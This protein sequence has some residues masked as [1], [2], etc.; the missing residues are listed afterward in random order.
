LVQPDTTYLLHLELLQHQ[1]LQVALKF[2]FVG[3]AQA[4]QDMQ[5]VMICAR[6]MAGVDLHQL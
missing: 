1:V 6:E 4:A 5:T 3:A 2:L